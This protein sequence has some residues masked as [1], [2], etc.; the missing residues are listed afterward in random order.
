MI[1][2]IVKLIRK[3]KAFPSVGRTGFG[4]A[5]TVLLLTFPLLSSAQSGLHS[6][7][8]F[9]GGVVSR[10]KMVEVKVRGRAISKYG[11]TFYHSVRFDASL[12]QLVKVTGLVTKDLKTAVGAENRDKGDDH[13]LIL[14]LPKQ[15]GQYRY[16][17]YLYG[18]GKKRIGITLVYME[19]SVSSIDKLREL[20]K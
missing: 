7:A 17:C 8:V 16:L 10:D 1:T 15:G 14:S 11:L 12:A 5:L 6:N 4:I 2:N 3:L 13:S 9:N 18:K 19:G 20:I